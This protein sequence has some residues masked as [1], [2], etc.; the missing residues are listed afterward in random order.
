M[1]LFQRHSVKQTQSTSIKSLLNRKNIHLKKLIVVDCVFEILQLQ[2]FL[3]S[4][5]KL[6]SSFFGNHFLRLRHFYHLLF[7]PKCCFVYLFYYLTTMP[8][9]LTLRN[10]DCSQKLH[11][12]KFLVQTLFFS[13]IVLPWN[14]KLLSYWNLE[15]LNIFC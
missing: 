2:K 13:R 12:N 1:F 6:F 14:V 7:A 15:N 5:K 11:H 8:L 3:K 9:K 10:Y 4:E